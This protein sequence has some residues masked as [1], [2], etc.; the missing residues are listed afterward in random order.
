VTSQTI[1]YPASLRE[2][3][4]PAPLAGEW[5]ARYPEIFDDRD[6]EQTVSQPN[7]HFCEWFT[8]IHIFHSTGRLSLIEKA[9]F[10]QSHSRKRAVVNR[11]LSA[12]RQEQLRKICAANSVQWPDLFVYDAGGT[13]VSFAEAKGPGDSLSPAQLASHAAIERDLDI[14]VIIFHLKESRAAV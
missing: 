5:R 3:F 10:G 4:W 9:E 14:K 7:K 2:R 1:F 11:F 8:A 6:L 12:Q 13:D